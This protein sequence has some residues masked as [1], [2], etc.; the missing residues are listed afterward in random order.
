MRDDFAVF[1]LS[2]GRPHNVKTCKTLVK[3]GYSGKWFLVLDN[4]DETINEYMDEF[5]EDI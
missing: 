2:H 5:G 3:Q 1:I 4:E